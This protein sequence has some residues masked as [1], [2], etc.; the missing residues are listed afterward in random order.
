MLFELALAAGGIFPFYLGLIAVLNRQYEEKFSKLMRIFL[1]AGLT[2]VPFFGMQFLGVDKEVIAA[3]FGPLLAVI[4]LAFSEELVKSIAL[5]FDKELKKHYYY[6]ILIGLGFAFFENISYLIGFDFS[7]TFVL[8]A[9]IR[10]FTVST[11]HAVFTSL[12]AHFLNKSSRKTKTLYY[13][14]GVLVAGSFHSVFNLLNHWELSYLIV[15]LLVLLIVY[16]HFDEPLSSKKKPAGAHISH[17]LKP[18]TSH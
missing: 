12:V 14:L 18:I 6:P 15:P 10:L 2:T 4:V 13:L 16:L 9:V 8:V 5:L 1:V 17:A 3:L 11:A 7:T